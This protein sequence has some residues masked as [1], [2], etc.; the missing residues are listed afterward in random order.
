MLAVMLTRKLWL[1]ELRN[2]LFE[3][4]E[5]IVQGHAFK[6]YYRQLV[7]AALEAIPEDVTKAIKNSFYDVIGGNPYA[8]KDS[9]YYIEE[10]ALY[11]ANKFVEHYREGLLLV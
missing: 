6:P 11:V 4:H 10:R 7:V 5:K 2:D 3:L 1:A 9:G 8:G